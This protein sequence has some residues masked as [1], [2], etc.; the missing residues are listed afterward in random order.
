MANGI[1]IEQRDDGLVDVVVEGVD[2]AA[3][4]GIVGRL[5][6]AFSPPVATRSARRTLPAKA[7]GR[8]KATKI[9]CRFCGKLIGPQGRISHERRNHPEQLAREAKK[10]TRLKARKSA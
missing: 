10:A 2:P 6:A 5:L 7:S 9:R 4:M 1:R 3:G 8:K